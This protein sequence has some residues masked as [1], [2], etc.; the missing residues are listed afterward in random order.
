MPKPLSISNK[1]AAESKTGNDKTPK[2]AV[3]KNAQM[4]NGSLVIVIPFVL[5]FKIVTM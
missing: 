2:I 5:R 4:V 1:T 3:M